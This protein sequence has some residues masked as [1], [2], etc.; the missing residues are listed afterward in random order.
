MAATVKLLK[1]I[2]FSPNQDV[3][4]NVR[5]GITWSFRKKMYQGMKMHFRLFGGFLLPSKGIRG[6]PNVAQG[7]QKKINIFFSNRGRK[8]LQS[9]FF[10][11]LTFGL[12]FFHYDLNIYQTVRR[13]EIDKTTGPLHFF[14]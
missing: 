8:T 5:R 11:F 10:A 12:V 4:Y 1:K 2:D 9:Y 13:F 3:L 6:M 7:E 14:F